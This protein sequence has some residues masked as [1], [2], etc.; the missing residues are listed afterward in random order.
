MRS[1]IAIAALCAALS[2]NP[3]VAQEPTKS[4]AVRIEV[5]QKAKA[6]IFIIDDEPVAMLDKSGLRVVNSIEYGFTL[7][8]TGPAYIKDKIEQRGKEVA[9]D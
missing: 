3:A 8:D 1:I 2:S 6:F 4:E 9:N 5:D 7:T